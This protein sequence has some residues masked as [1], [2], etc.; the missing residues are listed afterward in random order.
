MKASQVRDGA[1]QHAI[2]PASRKVHQ[3]AVVSLVLWC[4]LYK[5]VT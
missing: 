4:G 5:T 3:C 2:S 1:V